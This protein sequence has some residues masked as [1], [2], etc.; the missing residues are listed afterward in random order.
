MQIELTLPPA[1]QRPAAGAKAGA[2]RTRTPHAGV[3]DTRGLL[4]DVN[5]I[6]V[7]IQ[8]FNVRLFFKNNAHMNCFLKNCF[9]FCQDPLPPTPHPNPTYYL[10]PWALHVPS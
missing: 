10:L 3:T 6:T 1:E 7:I 9:V 2:A 4:L 5:L 8:P